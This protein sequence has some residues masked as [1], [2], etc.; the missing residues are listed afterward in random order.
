MVGNPSL[1]GARGPAALLS[2]FALVGGTINTTG[3]TELAALQCEHDTSNGAS[4]YVDGDVSFWAHKTSG[5]T[6]ADE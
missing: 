1:S 2:P 4:P 5:L 6:L 3:T